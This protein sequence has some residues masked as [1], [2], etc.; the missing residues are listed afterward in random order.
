MP[1]FGMRT[2]PR[3]CVPS[4]QE[5]AVPLSGF[6]ADDTAFSPDDLTIIGTA[7]S[8]ALAKLGLKDRDDRIVETV[9]RRIIRAALDGERDPARLCEIG[10]AGGAS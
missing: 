1:S 10:M 3:G 4:A 7:F 2:G 5:R 8:Q 9:A 6:L